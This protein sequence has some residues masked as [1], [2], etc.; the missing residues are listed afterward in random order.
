MASG[1]ASGRERFAQAALEAR[2]YALGLPALPK[3]PA[4]ETSMHQSTIRTGR[5][6]IPPSKIDGDGG[7]LSAELLSAQHMQRFG[8][9][10][11]IGHHAPQGE[12][13]RGL[14]D[15]RLEAWRV[16]ARTQRQIDAGDQ[17]ARVVARGGEFGVAPVTFHPALPSQEVTTDVSALQAGGVDAYIRRFGNHTASVCAME[18]SAE[19]VGETP[20]FRSL[21]SAFWRVVKCGTLGRAR[22]P[23]KSEK[24]SRTETMPR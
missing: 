16:I 18:N 13:L 15:R 6:P 9:V 8:I 2:E 24:S 10:G 21:L 19:Q 17:M 7:G 14:S 5:L 4:R 3:D 20:L 1:M 12:V 23:R 11:G 22:A